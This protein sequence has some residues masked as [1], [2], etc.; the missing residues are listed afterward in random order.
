M[1]YLLWTLP[2]IS[3]IGSVSPCSF[4]SA[5]NVSLIFH[6]VTSFLSFPV[7]PSDYSEQ[8]SYLL[9]Y[10]S[11]MT[12]D[13]SIAVSLLLQQAI[14]L[15]QEPNTST[16]ASIVMQNR[17]VL[18]IPIEVPEAPPAANQ[19]RRRNQPGSQSPPIGSNEKRESY[20]G[21]FPETFAKNIFDRSESLGINRAIANTVSELRVCINY[22]IDPVI[23][24]VSEEYHGQHPC[25][26]QP[27]QHLLSLFGLP[28]I[29]N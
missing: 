9:R 22:L 16:G 23:D 20:L 7:I 26:L 19:R 18:G 1:E 29:P 27:R 5:I 17:N 8:L 14:R 24:G 25:S 3:L 10:P 13:A 2:C 28:S 12:G 15:S 11:S 21:G 4:A 6:Y